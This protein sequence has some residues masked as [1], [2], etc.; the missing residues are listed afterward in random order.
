[1]E[2]FKMTSKLGIKP[3]DVIGMG[4]DIVKM[5]KS[6][7]NTKVNPK[8]LD[9]VNKKGEIPGKI[10][11]DIKVHMRSMKNASDNQIELFRLNIKDIFNA[12]FPPPVTSVKQPATSD[13]GLAIIHNLARKLETKNQGKIPSRMDSEAQAGSIAAQIQDVTGKTASELNKF[14]KSEAQLLK[15]LNDWNYGSALTRQKTPITT[16][17]KV[18]DFKG[19]TPRVIKGGKDPKF[20]DGGIAKLNAQLNQLPEYYLPM[21]NGG[22]PKGPAGITSLNGWGSKDESQNIAGADISASMD[23][24]PNDPGWGGGDGPQGPPS[25]I[26]PPK[27]PTLAE[28]E[29]EKKRK[30]LE[31]QQRR[32]REYAKFYS[33]FKGDT[34]KKTD[35]LSRLLKKDP[36]YQT[37]VDKG[38]LDWEYIKSYED[39]INKLIENPNIQNKGDQLGDLLKL[40]SGAWGYTTP[41][42]KTDDSLYIADIDK[43]D[44]TWTPG[45]TGD[46]KQERLNKRIAEVIGHEARHQVLGEGMNAPYRSLLSETEIN[47]INDLVAS[48]H[49]NKTEG[50]EIIKNL[51]HSWAGDPYSQKVDTNLADSGV[52]KN[53][54]SKYDDNPLNFKD[55]HE[56]VTTMGD[57]QSYNDPT[58]YDDIYGTIHG[59]MPR[60]LSSNVADELYDASLQAGK[61]FSARTLGEKYENIDPV[62]VEGL[63]NA[64]P[65]EDIDQALKEISTRQVMDFLQDDY[66]YKYAKGGIANHFRSK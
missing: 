5:G 41:W 51:G 57:F 63:K 31:E 60:H 59:N 40:Q 3:K 28:I 29:A 54:Q 24:N 47:K 25:V 45:W 46:S 13:N 65:D 38:L 26:N 8:L 37:Y 61:D 9:F 10:L 4:G 35:Y 62:M 39:D 34:K 49:M 30:A 14:I 42:S 43:F 56:L 44:P 52:W 66:E 17:E 32:A 27:G 15:I 23:K 21:A 36:L 50:D 58:I 7:F 6:L 55:T 33:K 53:Y 20:N 1:M 18:I 48:G 2:I 11:E 64:Y 12:K 19:W 16:S 22:L